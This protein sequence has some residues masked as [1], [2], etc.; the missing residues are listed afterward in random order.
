[1][2]DDCICIHALFDDGTIINFKYKYIYVHNK[3]QNPLNTL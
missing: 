3:N 1:M 2:I